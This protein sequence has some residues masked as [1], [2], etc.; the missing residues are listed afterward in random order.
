MLNTNQDK[1]Y[2]FPMPRITINDDIFASG[3][4][5]GLKPPYYKYIHFP[6]EIIEEIENE[7]LD[8]STYNK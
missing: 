3:V 5:V 1:Y 6:K 7:N 4:I 8:S 2:N